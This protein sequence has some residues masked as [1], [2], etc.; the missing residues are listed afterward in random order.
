MFKITYILPTID[1]LDNLKILIPRIL[2]L[3]I[4][5]KEIVVV[6]DSLGDETQK[7]LEN[8]Y[9]AKVVSFVKG[10]RQGLLSAIKKGISASNGNLIVWMD[11]DL[12]HPVELTLQMYNWINQGYDLVSA[13]RYLPESVDENVRGGFVIFLHKVLTRILNFFC[14]KLILGSCTD[15]TSGFLMVKSKVL[16]TLIF[17]GGYGEYYME[18]LSSADKNKYKIKEI[19]YHSPRRVYGESKTANNIFELISTGYPYLKK[20]VKLTLAKGLS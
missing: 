20:L 14:K 15:F 5:E 4:C 12:S 6:D 2:S 17:N 19:S 11:A 7:Y 1:E 13:S 18:L 9:N 16:E 10:E 8:G 3:D